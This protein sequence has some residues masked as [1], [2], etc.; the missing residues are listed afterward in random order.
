[1]RR[2]DRG[3]LA[4]R[5]RFVGMA[6]A[7][8]AGRAASAQSPEPRRD[9]AAAEV[10]FRA[11][12]AALAGGDAA[13]ACSKFSASLELDPAVA[14]LLQ[15]AECH[16]RQ[17]E[18]AAAWADVSRAEVLNRDTPGDQRRREL[19]AYANAL[20]RRLEKRV[21]RLRILVDH[22][23]PGLAL[24]RNDALLPNA[25]VGEAIP[26]DSGSVLIEASAPGYLPVRR[27]ITLIEGQKTDVT[28]RLVPERGADGGAPVG[29]AGPRG[30][31]QIPS[32]AWLSGGAGILLAGASVGFAVSQ[33]STQSDIDAHCPPPA[34]LCRPGYDYAAANDR[35]YRDFRLFVGLGTGALVA[36]GAGVTFILAAPRAKS[37]PGGAPASLRAG[38]LVSFGAPASLLAGGPVSLAAPSGPRAGGP[39]SFGAASGPAIGV[40]AVAG[41]SV[42]GLAIAGVF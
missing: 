14:T 21:P 7:L 10:L 33:A 42:A 38:G 19:D 27:Q 35:L 13:T 17:G 41:P 15:V 28:I 25:A 9:T 34:A 32:W 12:V 39:V 24:R 8:L 20:L 18:L 37:A 30:E 4:R 1:M 31:R 3:R 16:E 11:G 5:I 2:G 36:L 23:P 40:S 29:A 22:P 6:L 26:M